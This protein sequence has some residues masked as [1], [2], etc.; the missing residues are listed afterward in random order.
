MSKVI[1]LPV[2]KESHELGRHFPA[3]GVI[4]HFPSNR[5]INWTRF[6]AGAVLLV[7]LAAIV[8]NLI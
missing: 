6:A 4:E 3:P 7:S 8:I 1:Q 2:R 5:A